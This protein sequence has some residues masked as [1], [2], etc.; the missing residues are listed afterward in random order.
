MAYGYIARSIA[1]FVS[2]RE[3]ASG[4]EDAGFRVVAVHERL[5]GGIAVHHGVRVD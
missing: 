1:H 4:L 5:G 2:S 3:F